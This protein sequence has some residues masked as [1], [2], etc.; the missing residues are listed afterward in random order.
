MS[1]WRAAGLN[2]VQY[3]NIAARAVR[4]ALKKDLQVKKNLHVADYFEYFLSGHI[5]NFCRDPDSAFHFDLVASSSGPGFDLDL[6]LDKEP[7]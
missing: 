4:A 5:P 1:F 3:S 7:S 2:Y 6:K